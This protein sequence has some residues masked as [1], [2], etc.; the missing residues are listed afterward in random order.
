VYQKFAEKVQT[1]VAAELETQIPLNPPFPK[2]EFSPWDSNP[3]LEKHALSLV[4]GRGREDIQG[5]SRV[6]YAKN[7]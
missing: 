6:N 1:M 3:S 7:F 4:E 2:G 5:E